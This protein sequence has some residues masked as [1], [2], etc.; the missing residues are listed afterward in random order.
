MLKINIHIC[1]SVCIYVHVCVLCM[2]VRIYV[3]MGWY[4]RIYIYMYYDALFAEVAL[5]H[6][7]NQFP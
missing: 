7:N 4:V 2:F 5:H 6:W 3:C 1:H